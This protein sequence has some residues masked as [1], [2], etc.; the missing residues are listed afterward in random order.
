[1]NFIRYM[2][3]VFDL[4]PRGGAGGGIWIKQVNTW[5]V[6]VWE[7]S[8]CGGIVGGRVHF[9]WY[10]FSQSKNACLLNLSIF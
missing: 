3:F 10:E 5:V 9:V 8:V 4:S 6:G 2:F 7:A 1:M